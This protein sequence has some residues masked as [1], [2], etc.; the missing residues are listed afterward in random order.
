MQASPNFTND[1]QLNAHM[2][3]LGRLLAHRLGETPVSSVAQERLRASREQALVLARQRLAAVHHP[4]GWWQNAKARW[5][6]KPAQ[7]WNVVAMTAGAAAFAVSFVVVQ[8]V[9]E[10][11]EASELAEL[12]TELLTD[13]LPPEAY[14]DPA[15][16][17]FLRNASENRVK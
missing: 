9:N 5:A 8:A 16:M 4:R 3:R 2:D 14:S 15:F 17:R 13:E 12:D 7:W 10:A 1:R 11:R 6:Q